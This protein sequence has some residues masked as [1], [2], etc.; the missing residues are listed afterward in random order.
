MGVHETYLLKAILSIR[1]EEGHPRTAITVPSGATVTVTNGPIDRL[2]MVNVLWDGKTVMM[3]TVDIR[4]R[5]TLIRAGR[6]A[7]R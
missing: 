7:S 3:F 4:E 2:R 6:I 5:G 1:S